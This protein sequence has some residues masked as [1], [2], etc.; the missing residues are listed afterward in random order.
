[1]FRLLQIARCLLNAKS[2]L[3]FHC[4]TL[5]RCANARTSSAPPQSPCLAAARPLNSSFTPQIGR[6]AIALSH[7]ATDILAFSRALALMA[8]PGCAGHLSSLL[9]CAPPPLTFHCGITVARDGSESGTALLATLI[10][11]HH[12]VYACACCISS[13]DAQATVASSSPAFSSRPARH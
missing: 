4:P 8:V 3:Q 1:M 13:S 10:D 7:P 12:L 5:V 9:R 6:S 2:F 11:A